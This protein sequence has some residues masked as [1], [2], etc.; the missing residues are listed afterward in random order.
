MRYPCHTTAAPEGGNPGRLYPLPLPHRRSCLVAPA[1]LGD[2]TEKL[3]GAGI[4]PRG[5]GAGERRADL[6]GREERPPEL[7]GRFVTECVVRGD[8]EGGKA[9]HARLQP[10]P[11]GAGGVTHVHV[12]PEIRGA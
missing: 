4:A 8:V 1:M 2:E 3:S 10:E 5:C 7:L 12:T 6:G 11:E 9:G